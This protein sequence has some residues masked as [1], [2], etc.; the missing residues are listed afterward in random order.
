M[1]VLHSHRG[2][3][4]TTFIETAP[5][6]RSLRWPIAS[7]V[8]LALHFAWAMA[9]PAKDEIVRRYDLK[10]FLVRDYL[11]GTTSGRTDAIKPK[12]FHELLCQRVDMEET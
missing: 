3:G 10:P 7:L 4:V 12:H 8:S 6:N 9:P 1:A 5:A 2:E 11:T